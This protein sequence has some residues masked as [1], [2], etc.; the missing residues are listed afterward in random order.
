MRPRSCAGAGSA[1][2]RSSPD[3]RP[4]PR[5]RTSD[6]AM[7]AFRFASSLRTETDSDAA[8]RGAIDDVRAGLANAAP[9]LVLAFV[10]HHH[11]AAIEELG[12]RIARE[13]HARVLIGCTGE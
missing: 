8:V 1:R 10:S 3:V 6:D 7:T 4:L 2:S 11:G 5:A 12:P 9:D 13:T